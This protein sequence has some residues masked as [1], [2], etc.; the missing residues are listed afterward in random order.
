[1]PY[2]LPEDDPH[3]AICLHLPMIRLADVLTMATGSHDHAC[4]FEA[5]TRAS[6][7]WPMASAVPRLPAMDR[8]GRGAY[9]YNWS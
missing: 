3:A 4:F 2:P 7:S 9:V 5:R 8:P 1:M 6:L